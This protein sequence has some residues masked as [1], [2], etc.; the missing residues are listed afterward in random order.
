MNLHE[1]WK[2]FQA[3]SPKER[4]M[5]ISEQENTP[6]TITHRIAQ[7]RAERKRKEITKLI[8]TALISLFFSLLSILTISVLYLY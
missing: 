6:D 8:I 5:Y 3:M 4:K 2:T 1:K 7:R